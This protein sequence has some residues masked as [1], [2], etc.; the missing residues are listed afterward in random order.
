MTNYQDV[1]Q[2]PPL[3]RV[4]LKYFRLYSELAPASNPAEAELERSARREADQ[5]LRDL[6][7]RNKE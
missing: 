4:A 5:T 1:I 6:A 7:L 2:L 3:E